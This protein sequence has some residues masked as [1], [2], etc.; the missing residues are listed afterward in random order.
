M[1][2]CLRPSLPRS[3]EWT[4]RQGQSVNRIADTRRKYASGAVGTF[5]HGIALQG[6]NDSIELQVFADGVSC[7]PSSMLG[8]SDATGDHS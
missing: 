6:T 7:L 2:S 8:T 1:V 4:L 5:M 3:T